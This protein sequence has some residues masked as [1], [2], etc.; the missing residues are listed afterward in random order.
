MSDGRNPGGKRFGVLHMDQNQPMV[1]E[2]VR[3]G[4]IVNDCFRITSDH[5][6]EYT[7]CFVGDRCNMLTEVQEVELV[8]ELF[9][10][11]V[12]SIVY[13][14]VKVPQDH[15]MPVTGHPVLQK[16][17]KLIKEGTDRVAIPFVGGG[18]YTTLMFS[19]PEL[20]VNCVNYSWLY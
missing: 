13:M 7:A 6:V 5:N 4:D 15:M 2:Q 1:R 3:D 14:E 9:S 10:I 8:Q 20:L 16:G 19:K 12:S 11:G 17:P 18:W